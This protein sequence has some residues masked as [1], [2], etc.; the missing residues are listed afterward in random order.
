[1]NRAVFFDRDGTLIVDKGYLADP[2]GVELL[3]GAAEA[4]EFFVKARYVPIIVTNQSGIGRG[5]YAAA[6][7]EAVNART[8]ELFAARGVSI[9]HVYYCPHAP[10]DG[11][12]CRKPAPGM[13]LRAAAELGLDIERS[14]MIGD[15]PSD[16]E[17]GRA[18]GCGINV[19]L[20]DA[21]ARAGVHTAPSVLHAAEI[22]A[23]PPG[24]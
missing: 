14:I 18:A 15:K 3:P 4:V 12:E 11:C 17:A 5:Y 9:S 24:C 1:M 21:P 13:L 19:L 22:F 7:V 16:I 8:I 2:D 20:G 10:D 23:R 6:K